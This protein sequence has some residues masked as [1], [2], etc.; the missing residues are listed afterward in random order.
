MQRAVQRG[1]LL[2]VGGGCGRGLGVQRGDCSLKLIWPP[3]TQRDSALENV[4][5]LDY[6]GA[7]PM[8]PILLFERNQGPVGTNA[9]IAT[10]IVQQHQ[11]KYAE[12]LGLGRQ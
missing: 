6:F 7:I 8:R 11:R 3:S 10:C 12:R 1:D 5:P 9:R 4:E 2:P